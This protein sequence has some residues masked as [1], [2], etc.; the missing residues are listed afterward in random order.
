[1]IDFI[2]GHEIRSGRTLRA[3][4]VCALRGDFRWVVTGI[5]IQ[6]RWEDLASLLKFLQAYPDHDL[7]FSHGPPKV[8]HSRF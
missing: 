3:K 5:P 8:Q 4:S 7:N 1:M 2:I 6:N